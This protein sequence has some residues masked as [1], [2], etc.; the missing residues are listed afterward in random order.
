MSVISAEGG[1]RRAA[2]ARV[3]TTTLLR[4]PVILWIPRDTSEVEPDF[5]LSC[6]KVNHFLMPYRE[7]SIWP[8]LPWLLLSSA[9]GLSGAVAEGGDLSGFWRRYFLKLTAGSVSPMEIWMGT[10]E[11]LLKMR[12]NE[13]ICS[14][15]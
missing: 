8:F 1:E 11:G 7:R 2:N 6:T 15:S 12:S 5:W 13:D 4:L 9:S 10:L 14:W 3:G